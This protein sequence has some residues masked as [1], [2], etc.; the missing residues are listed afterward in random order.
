MTAAR[1]VEVHHI[2]H[3]ED[4]GPTDTA[5]LVALCPRHH[6]LHH[7]GGL[8]ISGD[9]DDPN[10]LI[11]TDARGRRLTGCGRPAPPGPD[12]RGATEQLNLS[13]S[14]YV[15]PTG[16][17]MDYWCVYFNETPIG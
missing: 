12:L 5:N 6:R 16:E 8:G 7:R 13:P 15:H 2:A 4:G 14:T 9:A 1:R 11:F 10:G 17:R 3:W